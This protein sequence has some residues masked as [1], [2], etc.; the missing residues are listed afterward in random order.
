LFVIFQTFA[1]QVAN[2]CIRNTSKGAWFGTRIEKYPA[3][4]NGRCQDLHLISL[5]NSHA[6]YILTL[7][8]TEIFCECGFQK[9]KWIK[10]TLWNTS[11]PT[12]LKTNILCAVSMTSFKYFQ[13]R[14]LFILASIKYIQMLMK[15][16]RI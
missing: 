6:F 10:T 9:L 13:K 11:T 8:A 3:V 2:S 5:F 12:H 14:K 4:I 16:R 15:S 1:R 7:P